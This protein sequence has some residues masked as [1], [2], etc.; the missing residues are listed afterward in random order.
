[1]F[2]RLRLRRYLRELLLNQ[3]RVLMHSAEMVL[4]KKKEDGE[5]V[6]QLFT[7]KKEL[8][9]FLIYLEHK[10][11]ESKTIYYDD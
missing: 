2:N 5:E 8:D 4:R 3:T 1:M 11:M 6:P 9:P 10:K 7:D